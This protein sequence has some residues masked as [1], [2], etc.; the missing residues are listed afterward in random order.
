MS[1]SVKLNLRALASGGVIVS[2]PRKNHVAEWNDG[3]VIDR[4]KQ[5]TVRSSDHPE[6]WSTISDTQPENG[7]AAARIPQKSILGNNNVTA[8]RWDE[9]GACRCFIWRTNRQEAAP[10]G[11][12][13]GLEDSMSW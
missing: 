6:V 7:Q 2:L 13:T 11:H 3:G 9:L 4:D 10:R 5:G 12:G 8:E 1:C